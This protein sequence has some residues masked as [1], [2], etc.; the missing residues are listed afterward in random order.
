MCMS[1]PFPCYICISLILAGIRWNRIT[2]DKHNLIFSSNPL[3]DTN[4]SLRWS[5]FASWIWRSIR[6]K[7][8]L[9]FTWESL[10]YNLIRCGFTIRIVYHF[11][12]IRVVQTDD[13]NELNPVHSFFSHIYNRKTI[14]TLKAWLG[15]SILINKEWSDYGANTLH[16]NN[17]S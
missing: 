9:F 1:M 6:S 8:I 16:S 7:S 17:Q 3:S 4:K 2:I 14:P 5:W 13:E 15:G 11:I 10:L 12:K